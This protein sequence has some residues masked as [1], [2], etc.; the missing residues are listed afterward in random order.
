[1]EISSKELSCYNVMVMAIGH[2]FVP[3]TGEKKSQCPYIQVKMVG[4]L[5]TVHGKSKLT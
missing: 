5:S 4:D 3:M 1:M 2:F